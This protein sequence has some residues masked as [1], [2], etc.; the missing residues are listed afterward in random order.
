MNAVS[1]PVTVEVNAPRFLGYDLSETRTIPKEG[2]VKLTFDSSIRLSNTEV[3][4]KGILVQSTEKIVVIAVN[5]EK[6]TNDAYL[7]LPEPALGTTYYAISYYPSTFP[8]QFVV[9]GTENNTDVEMTL[10]TNPNAGAVVFENNTYGPGDTIRLSID[11]FYSVQIQSDGDLTGS[12]I[13][14][15]K[16]VGFLSGNKRTI[17]GNGS[18]SSDH[19]EE[20]VPSVN[21]WG[22]K[23]ATV[24][25]PGRIVGEYYKVVASSS[26]TLVQVECTDSFGN[27]SRFAETMQNPGDSVVLHIKYEKY[28]SFVADNAIMLAQFV[29]SQDPED[30]QDIHDPAMIL[31][32]PM[33]QYESEY[34]FSTP[35][36]TFGTYENFFL[37]VIKSD[38]RSGMRVDNNGLPSET[39]FVEIPGTDLVGGHVIV[40]D[41][42]HSVYHISPIVV[43][44]GYLYGRA[45]YETYGIPAG[46]RL[47]N[48]NGPC[49]RSSNVPG[50]VVDNDCDGLIDE[51]LDNALDDDG[52]GE[53][54]EDCAITTNPVDGNW[55]SWLE[56]GSCSV[57]CTT[58]VITSGQ[59]QRIRTCSE[60]SPKYDGKNCVGQSSDNRICEPARCP[61]DGNWSNWGSWNPCSMTCNPYTGSDLIVSGTKARSRTCINPIPEHGGRSCEGNASDTQSCQDN[62]VCQD[63]QA[64]VSSDTCSCPLLAPTTTTRPSPP[65]PKDLKKILQD[66]NVLLRRNKKETARY[67]RSL[68]SASDARGSSQMI[69][70]VMIAVILSILL[71]FMLM[72]LDKV[73]RFFRERQSSNI[74]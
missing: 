2:Y 55:A 44:A 70:F 49:S 34:Q 43:F 17:I 16:P 46:S 26:N 10:S 58:D 45:K 20:F 69:G 21:K 37:F 14:T 38:K 1:I 54:D 74:L 18:R 19:L 39:V 42:Y 40:S 25:I 50:D 15:D 13:R 33:E 7:A 67:K 65:T 60:P 51:E 31:I 5:R 64:T 62:S 63:A 6:Y 28:C 41:G 12:Y 29:H 53:I 11:R 32:T 52:D 47:A 48:V 59:S 35:R 57:T 8:T 30:S 24:P 23:F 27:R 3:A 36:F 66:L 72:D 73:F 71:L 56:W 61:V 68:S 9:I 22:K 4:P